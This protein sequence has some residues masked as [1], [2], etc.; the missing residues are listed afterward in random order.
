[1]CNSGNCEFEN[2]F[3]ECTCDYKSFEK[4]YGLPSCLVGGMVQS[5]E[6][7]IFYIEHQDEIQNI[8]DDYYKENKL[9][10]L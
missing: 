4:E 10:E 9:E 7:R 3:G 5:E 6:D 8:I 2:Y 1:M